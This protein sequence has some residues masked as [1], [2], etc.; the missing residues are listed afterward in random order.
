M[1]PF[2]DAIATRDAQT[3]GIEDTNDDGGSFRPPSPRRSTPC[4]MRD[5]LSA[6]DEQKCTDGPPD[7]AIGTSSGQPV[8]A[9][10]AH[11]NLFPLVPFVLAVMVTKLYS[12][13][14][15]HLSPLLPLHESSILMKK[16][17]CVANSR[18]SEHSAARMN[19]SEKWWRM[20][21]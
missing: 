11:R 12:R 14:L 8:V 16:A 6:T 15:K 19:G 1:K 20:R 9:L 17:R 10:L 7:T 4:S 3:R 18:S 21:L 5:A 13:N 2:A